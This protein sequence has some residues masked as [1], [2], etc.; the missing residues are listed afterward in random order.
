MTNAIH[1][2]S[3]A[4]KDVPT[5]L[6]D[7]QL[8]AIEA[9]HAIFATCRTVES[10]PIVPPTAVPNPPTPIVRFPKPSPLRYPSPTSKDAHGKYRVTT[11]KGA[12][13]QT[14]VILKVRQVAFNSRGDQ[15][16]IAARTRSQVALPPNISPFKAQIH[17]IDEPV[18]ARK[19]SSTGLHHFT[20]PSL[21][22]ALA[23]Q[24]LT[25]AAH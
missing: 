12:F 15:E 9:V 10:A 13:K 25:H 24:I 6:C 23:A 16:P 2:F 7:Y 5:S 14:S 22:R 21:S 20:T 8:A 11:S 18:A 4:L 17:P 1:F 3:A 19:R